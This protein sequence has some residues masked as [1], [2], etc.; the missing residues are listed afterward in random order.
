[1]L[2]PNS[3]RRTD[4]LANM[5]DLRI[6][7]LNPELRGQESTKFRAT[8]VLIWPYSSSGCQ[9]ALLLADPDIRSRHKKSQVRAR[10]SGFSAEAI[11][12]KGVGIGDEVVLGLQGAEFVKEGLLSTPGESIE[13]ELSYTQTVVFQAFRNGSELTSPDTAHTA[14]SSFVP[15]LLFHQKAAADPNPSSR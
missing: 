11:A 14:S 10:F 7:A 13:W 15:H 9:T 5:H 6:S 3:D 12:G 4:S 2:D 8:V 1:M